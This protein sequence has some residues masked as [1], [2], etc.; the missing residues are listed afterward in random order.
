[1]GGA[2]ANPKFLTVD[3]LSKIFSLE[4]VCPKMPN[5]GLKTSILG[6]FWRKS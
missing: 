2:V 3:K 6:K 4:N 1:M 5:L